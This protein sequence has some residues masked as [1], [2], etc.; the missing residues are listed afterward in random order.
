M[1]LNEAIEYSLL[2]YEKT[3]KDLAAY[4]RGGSGD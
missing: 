3:F 2:M 4:D 1:T